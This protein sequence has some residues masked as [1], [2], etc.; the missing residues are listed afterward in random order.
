MKVQRIGRP[1]RVGWRNCQNDLRLCFVCDLLT[2]GLHGST[3]LVYECWKM[4]K[5]WEVEVHRVSLICVLSRRSVSRAETLSP[6]HARVFQKFIVRAASHAHLIGRIKHS[7]C[8]CRIRRIELRLYCFIRT[9]L[10]QRDRVFVQ[11]GMGEM[12]FLLHATGTRSMKLTECML[13]AWLT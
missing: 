2:M 3:C 7:Y 8:L 6:N 9:T 13:L 5:N 4:E 11:G 10:S 1:Q 12:F